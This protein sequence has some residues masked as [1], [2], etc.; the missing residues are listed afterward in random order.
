ME[1][2][3]HPITTHCVALYFVLVYYSTKGLKSLGNLY[4]LL[5]HIAAVSA[6]ATVEY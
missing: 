5:T 2:P 6:A 4:Q 3:R 1:L